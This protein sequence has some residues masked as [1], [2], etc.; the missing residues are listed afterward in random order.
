MSRDGDVMAG[1]SIGEIAVYG[2]LASVV[3]GAVLILGGHPRW[4]AVAV[5]MGALLVVAALGFASS[6]APRASS[7]AP[8]PDQSPIPPSTTSRRGRRRRR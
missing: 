1:T 7:A 6:R 8:R 2:M 3:A 4:Y 5:V